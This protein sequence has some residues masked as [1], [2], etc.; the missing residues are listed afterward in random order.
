MEYARPSPTPRT[1]ETLKRDVFGTVTLVR[2]ADGLQVRRDT[3][4]ARWWAAG[5][6]RSLAKREAKALAAA[7]EVPD[8][9][10]LIS[11]DGRV[12]VRSW[13]EGQ[14]MHQAKPGNPEYFRAALALVRKLHTAGVVHNDLAKEPNWLVGPDGRPALVDFQLA[15][16]PRYRGRLFRMLA[17]DDL[18]HLLKHKRSYCPASLTARQRAV[19][20]RR[21]PVAALWARTGKPLYRFV[22]RGL[23]GW[24]DREGA[25]D[26]GAP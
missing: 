3:R 7:G 12:L 4:S 20:A 5:L 17:W 21:S 8:I 6:A 2:T 16:R 13:L 10:R 11:W 9:P 23:L 18:R 24:S 19:L 22:T 15:M 25:G 14:P 1:L 26:R